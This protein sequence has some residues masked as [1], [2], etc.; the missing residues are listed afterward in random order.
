[1]F[2]TMVAMSC[3]LMVCQMPY[4]FSRMAGALGLCVACVNSN[5]GKVVCIRVL[6]VLRPSIKRDLFEF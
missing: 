1:M 5:L 4:S 2:A 3:Q 6:V